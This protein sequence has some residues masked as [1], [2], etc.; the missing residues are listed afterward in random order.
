MC[1][2]YIATVVIC[3]ETPMS[4]YLDYRTRSFDIDVE[5]TRLAVVENVAFESTENRMQIYHNKKVNIW[6][7][8]YQASKTT[9]CVPTYN[10]Y[11]AIVCYTDH[12]YILVT[13]RYGRYPFYYITR[14]SISLI[15][16]KCVNCMPILTKFDHIFHNTSKTTFQI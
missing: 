15:S 9:I 1:S 12:F 5:L 4:S 10:I 14:M 8:Y 3:G 16:H 13:A 7:T 6:H 11:L 2:I